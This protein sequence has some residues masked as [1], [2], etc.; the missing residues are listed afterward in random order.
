MKG[1]SSSG[2]PALRQGFQPPMPLRGELLK[3]RAPH[4]GIGVADQGHRRRRG[5]VARR[6]LRLVDFQQIAHG[7]RSGQ[8]PVLQR[9]RGLAGG[10]GSTVR[11]FGRQTR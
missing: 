10:R 11:P 6:A 2:Q 5:G 1:R 9:Q 8:W 7:S 4:R 3:R